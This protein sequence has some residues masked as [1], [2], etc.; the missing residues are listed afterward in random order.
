MT[1]YCSKCGGIKEGC[2]RLCNCPDVDKL[3][4]LYERTIRTMEVNY[5]PSYALN[6]KD[7]VR[8][9]LAD[10]D[11]MAARLQSDMSRAEYLD[12][13]RVIQGLRGDLV[14]LQSHLDNEA[15]KARLRK[16]QIKELL[17]D[18]NTNNQQQ[19]VGQ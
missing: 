19:G 16:E 2:G 8:A 7:Y 3:K 5:P 1:V 9:I 11:D 17:I 4:G 10:R 13:V 6:V 15:Y 12:K 18:I 14:T